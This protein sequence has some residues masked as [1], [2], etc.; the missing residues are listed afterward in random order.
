MTTTLIQYALYMC[1][2]TKPFPLNS[3]HRLVWF[4]QH[5]NIAI[6]IR[7][8]K[9]RLK[10]PVLK[11]YSEV[12]E[13]IDA[14]QLALVDKETVIPQLRLSDE[15]LTKRYPPKNRGKKHGQVGPPILS[16][17]VEY[18]QRWLLFLDEITPHLVDVWRR[19][20]SLLSLLEPACE[21]HGFAP[22]DSYQVLYRFLANSCAR[23]SVI[24]RRF[25][26]GNKGVKRVG[27]GFNLGRMTNEAKRA[28]KANNN[29]STTPA[30]LQKIRDTYT[31]TVKRGVS[32]VSPL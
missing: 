22:N 13:W 20:I 16:A 5:E 19:S 24:P 28:G 18:R 1:P 6:L 3:L 21:K 26:C 11:T 9:K 4:S 32:D 31:E 29:F 27:K 25:Y 23:L 2:G 12:K 7:T 10:K 14:G 8:D 15:A 30:W 17:P